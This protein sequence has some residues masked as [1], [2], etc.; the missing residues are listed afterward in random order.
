MRSWSKDRRKSWST[1]RVSAGR[2]MENVW[3]KKMMSLHWF[4]SCVSESSPCTF[5]SKRILLSACLSA[6]WQS[7]SHRCDKTFQPNWP[8]WSIS[9]CRLSSASHANARTKE[10]IHTAR[11]LRLSEIK[12]FSARNAVANTTYL[13]KKR[14]SAHLSLSH[15]SS[16]TSSSPCCWSQ[17]L[18]GSS[19]WTDT[20]KSSMHSQTQSKLKLRRNS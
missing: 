20:L 1:R 9:K 10:C 6:S 4:A 8:I 16:S 19:S 17:W 14:E 2:R 3:S 12:G 7:C 13:S 18:Q 5:T 15:S 11:P